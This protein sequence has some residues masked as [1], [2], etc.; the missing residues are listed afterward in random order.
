MV[1]LLSLSL[2]QLRPSLSLLSSVGVPPINPSA[3]KGSSTLDKP[4]SVVASSTVAMGLE[5]LLAGHLGLDPSEQGDRFFLKIAFS[6][7][8]HT[9]FFLGQLHSVFLVLGSYTIVK[10]SMCFSVEKAS[11]VTRT[12]WTTL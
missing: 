7:F 4:I 9:F 12:S 5:H 11:S 6:P 2:A 10:S 1:A 3:P 8:S